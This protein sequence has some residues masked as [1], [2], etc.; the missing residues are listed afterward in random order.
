MHLK[1]QD[2]IPY[3]ISSRQARGGVL[4]MASSMSIS[5]VDIAALEGRCGANPYHR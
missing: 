1:T 3:S 4:D 2:S 5:C